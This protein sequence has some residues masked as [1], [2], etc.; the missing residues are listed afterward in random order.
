MALTGQHHFIIF[1]FP[2]QIT[3]TNFCM[4]RSFKGL[5]EHRYSL[6]YIVG[7][8]IHDHAYTFHSHCLEPIQ[9]LSF[10]SFLPVKSP[11]PFNLL[12]AVKRFASI[13]HEQEEVDYQVTV[14]MIK[15]RYLQGHQ[16]FIDQKLAFFAATTTIFLGQGAW[17]DQSRATVR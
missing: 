16:T 2:Q 17:K 11:L 7:S 15:P 5:E 1:F 9:V 13:Q 14:L 3:S 10:K 8:F 4:L 12:A 6:L